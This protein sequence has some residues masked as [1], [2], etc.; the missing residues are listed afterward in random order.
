MSLIHIF[1]MLK[2]MVKKICFVNLCFR[3]VEQIS[4]NVTKIKDHIR[5]S[6]V[7]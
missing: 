4:I 6:L 3:F 2:Y 1:T 5:I 7:I